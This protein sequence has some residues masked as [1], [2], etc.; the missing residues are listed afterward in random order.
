MRILS[1]VSLVTPDGAY[2]GPVRVALNQA[3]A[4]IKLGHQVTLAAAT[5]GYQDPPLEIDGVPIRL[6]PALTVLP[7]T[8]FA[9][10]SSPQLLRWLPNAI[11]AAEVVHLHTARDLITL[12][13]AALTHRA[14]VPYFLQTHGMIDASTNPLAAPLDAVA[15]RRLLRAA[16][17]V[18]HLTEF[19]R[20]QLQQVAGDL[21]F[22]P[23]ANGVPSAAATPPPNQP[24]VLFLARLA[25]RKRPKLFVEAA[26][27][28]H[29]DYPDTSFALVGPD[30]GEGRTVEAAITAAVAEGA[31]VSWEGALAPDR[32]LERLGR[33]SVYVLPSV[34][35]PY[36]MSV[37]EAISVGRPVVVT[38]SC[39]LA[40]F[41]R[42]TDAGIVVDDSVEALTEAIAELLADPA[43]A[44][45]RGLRGQTAV[46][47]ELSMEAI[48]EQ[49]VG[50]YSAAIS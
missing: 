31:Q 40:D 45:Q 26:R 6:F 35:E 21:R 18:F 7:G 42:R 22:V 50:Q 25:S 49:L 38:E 10:I 39:G 4:L 47:A 30:E 43:A 44:A 12:P 36:P 33:S 23:L 17:G 32:T 19:E 13:A 1:V 14:G 48:A 3:A 16:A 11:R 41:V 20:S 9:G 34:N 24:E 28:L 2:G 8:G 5:R 27:R 15:T 29:A 46:R 37:L